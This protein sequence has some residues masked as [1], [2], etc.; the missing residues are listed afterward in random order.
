MVEKAMFVLG[1]HVKTTFTKHAHDATNLS[2][3]PS[4]LSA[5]Q[6]GL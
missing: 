4:V 5:K 1:K 3:L 6:M 2:G